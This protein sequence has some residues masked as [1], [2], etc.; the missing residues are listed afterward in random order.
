MLV[1]PTMCLIFQRRDTLLIPSKYLFKNLAT[2]ASVSPI[3]TRGTT[4]EREDIEHHTTL[5]NQHTAGPRAASKP[6]SLAATAQPS[7][8][9]SLCGCSRQ[10]P[11]IC[12]AT[13]TRQALAKPFVHIT[14][15]RRC[16][17][18]KTEALGL[19]PLPKGLFPP[20]VSHVHLS[21]SLSGGL[22][23]HPLLGHFPLLSL[24][25]VS[26]FYYEHG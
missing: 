1:L 3:W 2:F 14:L 12:W 8:L 15:A 10:W 16:S 18:Q 24:R 22:R 17:A 20:L 23:A 13:V 26:N 19:C 6:A 9:L 25:V 4:L 21:T 7:V 5:Q 11:A